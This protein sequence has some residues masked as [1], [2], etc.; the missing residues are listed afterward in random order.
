MRGRD[1]I[2]VEGFIK[3]VRKA[4]A[5]C[6]EQSDLLD[7]IIAQKITEDAERSIRHLDIESYT[8]RIPRREINTS[9]LHQLR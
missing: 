6:R 9:M 2:G 8:D 7:L 1:D 4:R 3:K 5:K